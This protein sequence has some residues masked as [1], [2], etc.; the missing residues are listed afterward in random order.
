MTPTR[1][2]FL[3]LTYPEKVL[4]YVLIFASLGVMAWQIWSRSRLWMKGKPTW[5]HGDSTL[6]RLLAKWVG[7]VWSYV[8]LQRKVRSSRTWRSSIDG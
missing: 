5:W 4:F 8:V 1:Q 6:G 7:N 2:E 3:H